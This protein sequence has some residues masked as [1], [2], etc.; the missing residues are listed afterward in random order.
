M[1]PHCARR[2]PARKYIL[3]RRTRVDGSQASFPF[4]SNV[5]SLGSGGRVFP[6]PGASKATIVTG[7]HFRWESP[8]FFPVQAP[9]RFSKRTLSKLS[10]SIH[11]KCCNSLGIGRPPTAHAFDP[12][13]TNASIPKKAL[14]RVISRLA[15][16]IASTAN[17]LGIRPP[18]ADRF[19]GAVSSRL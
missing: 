8:R 13:K 10:W 16:R 12:Q 1:C 4:T 14:G 15:T 3:A 9:S 18:V 6:L 19:R 17:P 5:D 11:Q 7:R 2:V